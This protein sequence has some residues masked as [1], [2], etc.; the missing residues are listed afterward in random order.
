[1][2]RRMLRWA[3]LM[4]V[5]AAVT[6]PLDLARR[7]V[8]RA[9]RRAG[10]RHRAGAVVAGSEPGTP[11]G[12]RRRTGR[13]RRL[14]RHDGP[15]RR[16]RRAGLGLADR[17]RRRRRHPGA[18]HRRRRAARPAPR[19]HP[20]DRVAGAGGG[21]RVRPGRHRPRTRRRRPRRRGRAVPA[22]RAGHRVDAGGRDAGLSRRQDRTTPRSSL[23]PIR[24]LGI[25]ASPCSSRWSWSAR[26]SAG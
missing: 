5:T 23:K 2:V 9:V 1:M 4:A 11:H 17:G 19:R 21:R 26:P 12:R 7:P 20:A 3:L 8:R 14:H 18:Q 22:G 15:P 24:R 6:V 13:A 10:R 16:G 25:S